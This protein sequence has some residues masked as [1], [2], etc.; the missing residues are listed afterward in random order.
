MRLPVLFMLC[1]ATPVHA[2]GIMLSGRAEMG[3]LG[4]DG[5]SALHTDV[6]LRFRYSITTDG[7]L[8]FGI[9]GDLSDLLDDDEDP[10]ERLRRQ[11]DQ[12]PVRDDRQD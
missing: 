8:T 2:D 6:E 11:Q 3:L 4:G 1:L 7:G 12:T 5:G 9:E 10:Y